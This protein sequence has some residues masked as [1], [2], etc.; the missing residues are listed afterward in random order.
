MQQPIKVCD[1]KL[2]SILPILCLFF[3]LPC[4]ILSVLS[5]I[6]NQDRE[7][8]FFCSLGFGGML[9]LSILLLVYLLRRK[10]LLYEDHI[11]YTPAFGRA[12]TFSYA[13]IRSVT[14]SWEKYII[15]DYNGAKLAVFEVNMPAAP[16]AIAYLEEKHVKIEPRKLLTLPAKISSR[17]SDLGTPY[18]DAYTTFIFPASTIKKKKRQLRAVRLLSLFLCIFM[19]VLPGKWVQAISILILLLLYLPFL[20]YYPKIGLEKDKENSF[21]PFPGFSCVIGLFILYTTLMADYIKIEKGLWIPVSVLLTL[22]LSAPYLLL[23]RAWKIKV[24]P[25]EI[26][27]TVTHFFLLSLCFAPSVHYLLSIML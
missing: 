24:P 4:L 8:I 26:F 27:L 20:V 25:A 12:R 13:E 6:Q 1:N 22:V 21:L 7:T 15:Y 5:G 18:R 17:L 16:M 14:P 23:L 2:L 3:C 9:L 10:L 11:S 19:I